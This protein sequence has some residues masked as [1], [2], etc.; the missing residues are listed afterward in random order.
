M[1]NTAMTKEKIKAFAL[2]ELREYLIINDV[3]ILKKDDIKE[4]Y[5]TMKSM[6]YFSK[7]INAG[8]ID[9]VRDAFSELAELYEKDKDV[10]EK[11]LIFFG[12]RKVMEKIA[13][14]K[15]KR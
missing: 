14:N 6:G 15:I 8:A 10:V 1:D 7:A 5:L 2:D 13:G 9:V 11:D 12:S 3:E 4:A